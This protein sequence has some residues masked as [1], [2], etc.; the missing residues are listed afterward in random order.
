ME[1]ELLKYL[2]AVIGAVAG[3]VLLLLAQHFLPSYSKEKGK[4]LATKEDIEAITEKIESVKVD[5][6]KQLELYKLQLWQEQQSHLWVQE[7]IKLKI[8]MF[9]NAVVNV[10]KLTNSVKKYQMVL[11][12]RELALAAAGI[13]K[14]ESNAGAQK[15]YWEMHLTFR[16]QAESV[17]AEFRDISADM[18]GLYALFTVYFSTELSSSLTKILAIAFR[19]V[20]LKMT[21]AQFS[22]RLQLEYQACS[23]LDAARQKVGAYYDQICDGVPLAIESQRFFELLKTHV[24]SSAGRDATIDTRAQA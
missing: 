9:K 24:N 10:A 8:D 23:S 22:E 14:N 21:P 18:G 7:E 13:S 12:E 20:E 5:Y 16:E 3:S 17:Y 2:Y 15:L 11:S 19:A 1:S 6:A 4:N